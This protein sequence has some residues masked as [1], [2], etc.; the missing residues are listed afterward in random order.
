MDTLIICASVVGLA[1]WLT[2]LIK[3]V[4][5]SP[6]QTTD[7]QARLAE[8]VAR[9]VR[10]D[11]GKETERLRA[12]QSQQAAELRKELTDGLRE[13][14]TE[15]MGSLAET[16][17]ESA[18]SVADFSAETA[19]QTKELQKNVEK[20]L[21][22]MRADN[23]RRLNEMREVVG[24]KLQKTLEA[25]LGESFRQVS[26]RLDAVTKHMAEVQQIQG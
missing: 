26:E 20:S 4:Q 24:E 25:R 13:S 1:L 16:R 17:R 10:E 14:R 11:I 19:E 23:E 5:R 9:T 12:A 3:S 7:E 18:K 6:Q 15:I 2:Y 22:N 21:E 8:A